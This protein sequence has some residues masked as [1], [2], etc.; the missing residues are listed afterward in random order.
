MNAGAWSGALEVETYEKRSCKEKRH[1]VTLES[2]WKL[3]KN[4]GN[5]TG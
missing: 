2:T 3:S 4:M 1:I 5:K